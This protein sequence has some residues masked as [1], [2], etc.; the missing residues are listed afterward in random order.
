MDL[1]TIVVEQNDEL[2]GNQTTGTSGDDFLLGDDSDNSFQG[3]EG[4]DTL[5]GNRG[6][7]FLKGNEGND[8][9]LGGKD[10]DTLFGGKDND[11]LAGDLGNDSVSGDNGEDT[12]IGNSGDDTLV[13]G[14]EQDT[15]DYSNLNGS[16][17]FFASANLS[18]ESVTFPDGPGFAAISGV[19]IEVDK[20]GI[21]NDLILDNEEFDPENTNNTFMAKII[22]PVDSNSTFEGTE[23]GFAGFID[24]SQNLYVFSGGARID[25]S[26]MV[27]IENFDNA[28]G[29]TNSSVIIGNS[30]D[31]RLQGRGVNDSLD[32]QDGNDYL[33]T[34]GGGDILVGGNGNDTLD[35]SNREIGPGDDFNFD[36]QDILTGGSGADL[37]ILG[38]SQDS[39]YELNQEGDFANIKDLSSEDSIQ[40]SAGS[41]YVVRNSGGQFDLFLVQESGEDLIAKINSNDAFENFD[42]DESFQIAPQETVGVFVGI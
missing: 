4:N 17:E 20:G 27:E 6:N 25:G 3:N 22:A 29:S 12:F 38:D 34:G 24:L 31:N 21:G 13:G 37:F 39:Y 16:H 11:T 9:L 23:T 2:T 15:Y 42:L 14:T 35:G 18:F 32:G 30:G 36:A 19:E 8:L 41:E 7:D 1:D 5:Q 33:I 28:I 10:D 40:L 26:V